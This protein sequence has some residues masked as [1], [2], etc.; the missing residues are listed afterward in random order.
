MEVE[1]VLEVIDREREHVVFAIGE[2]EDVLPRGIGGKSLVVRLG[3]LKPQLGLGRT[4]DE[5]EVRGVLIRRPCFAD[6]Y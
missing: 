4:G 3:R 6:F 5:R 2:L 1:A